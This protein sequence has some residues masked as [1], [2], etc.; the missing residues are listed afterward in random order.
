MRLTLYIGKQ[1]I[2]NIMYASWILSLFLTILSKIWARL[3]APC[4]A[5]SSYLPR[6]TLFL[7]FNIYN[8]ITVK[9]LKKQN[10]CWLNYHDDEIDEKSSN[11]TV[12]SLNQYSTI[13][14]HC[15]A[16]TPGGSIANTCSRVIL[17]FLWSFFNFVLRFLLSSPSWRI[18]HPIWLG[19]ATIVGSTIY[20][21]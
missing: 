4:L 10:I 11:T 2:K 14:F 18:A 5:M 6:L 8:H 20:R 13:S 9:I 12:F 16:I 1:N 17:C 7:S 21:F 19:G 3:L 15:T